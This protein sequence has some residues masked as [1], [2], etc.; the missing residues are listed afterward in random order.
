MVKANARIWPWLSYVCW[1]CLTA[2]WSSQTFQLF[3]QLQFPHTHSGLRRYFWSDS[4]RPFAI[5]SA[6][7][8]LCPYDIA[9]CPGDIAFTRNYDSPPGGDFKESLRSSLC[10]WQEGRQSRM[11]MLTP[12]FVTIPGFMP[13]ACKHHASVLYFPDIDPT[14]QGSHVP[15]LT[16]SES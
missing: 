4:G 8:S 15:H 12:P 13:R 9:L 2:A 6:E 16:T 11:V 14:H 3:T 10:V 1:I 7:T 5:I